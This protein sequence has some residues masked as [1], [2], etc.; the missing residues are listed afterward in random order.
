VPPRVFFQGL[1]S[2]SIVISRDDVE[3]RAVS[4]GAE[5]HALDAGATVISIVDA[6]RVRLVNLTITGG[7][8]G[9]AASAGASFTATGL[10]VRQAET[11]VEVSSGALGTLNGTRV[12]QNWGAGIRVQSGG[13]LGLGGGVVADTPGAGIIA[14]ASVIEVGATIIENNATGILLAHNASLRVKGAA[15]RSNRNLGVSMFGSSSATFEGDASGPALISDNGL[16]LGNGGIGVNSSYVSLR[17]TTIEDNRG[18]GVRLFGTATLFLEG[19]VLIRRNNIGV[20]LAD[21]SILATGGGDNPAQITENLGQG[22]LCAPHPSVAHVQS[23]PGFGL[24]GT[25]V[26]G[27]GLGGEEQINCPGLVVP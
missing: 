2:E 24:S 27:N 20:R 12:E 25:D 9:V 6:R 26:F 4:A 23:T 3:L 14:D 8:R 18:P 22:V 21:A 17:E 7:S 5:L 13:V 16:V 11:G 1:C 19:G 15:I 10:L